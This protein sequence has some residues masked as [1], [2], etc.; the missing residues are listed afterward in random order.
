MRILVKSGVPIIGVLMIF[1]YFGC[2]KSIQESTPNQIIGPDNRISVESSVIT[3]Q[4]GVIEA[5][6]SHCQAYISSE[7]EVSTA[8][9]CIQD[10]PKDLSSFRFRGY[11]G[12]SARIVALATLDL[13]KDLISFKVDG[14]ASQPLS[15]GKINSDE[16]LMIFARNASNTG[17][18]VS[19][20]AIESLLD[21]NAA[22]AYRCD[23]EPGYSGVPLIQ[24]K[25]IV[26]MH[27]GYSKQLKANVGLNDSLSP[28]KDLDI[29]GISDLQPECRC[30]WRCPGS[31][32]IRDVVPVDPL[33]PFK[34]AIIT[35]AAKITADAVA[36]EARK[37]GWTTTS[38]A[39][40]G[41]GII[42]SV[43]ITSSAAICSFLTVGAAACPAFIGMAGPTVVTATCAQLCTDKHLSDCQ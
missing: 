10:D 28:F 6:S 14:L 18:L 31:C 1:C 7:S 16:T 15:S 19:Q 9:H 25:K 30:G 17:F 20:C 4:L 23:T 24:G 34:D 43:A 21:Q 12:K 13:S 40:V 41:T 2:E 33:E 5:S 36:S 27:L 8:A 42:T 39:V 22:V 29:R 11:K 38:C 26:G 32:S 35:S 37:S 3:D